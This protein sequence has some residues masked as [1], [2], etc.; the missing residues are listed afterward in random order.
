M[1]HAMTQEVNQSALLSWWEEQSFAGKEHYSLDEKGTLTFKAADKERVIAN[2]T[3]GNSAATFKTL[4]DKFAELQTRVSEVKTEW[5]KNEDRSKLVGKVERLRE[6]ISHANA[7]GD[8]NSL[9]AQV[10]EWDKAIHEMSEK[11]YQERLA[12]VKQSEELANAENFKE[13]TQALR[14]L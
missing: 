3:E 11:N 13:T 12:L 6:N 2:L 10:A 14:D 5:D 1:D 4:T 9:S 8:L 7:V